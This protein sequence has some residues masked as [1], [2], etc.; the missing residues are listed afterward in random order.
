[1]RLPQLT[2]CGR[3]VSMPD[4]ATGRFARVRRPRRAVV[5]MVSLGRHVAELYR[6]R[7]RVVRFSR[8]LIGQF[9]SFS[10]TGGTMKSSLWHT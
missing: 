1:M 9:V 8:I 3:S 4:T 6:Q 2:G 5:G 10:S 7:A